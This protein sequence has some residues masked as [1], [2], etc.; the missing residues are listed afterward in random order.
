[1]RLIQAKVLQALRRAAAV[2]TFNQRLRKI[3]TRGH[4]FGGLIALGVLAGLYIIVS[5]ATPVN[6]AASISATQTAAAIVVLPSNT[7]S[8]SA[9]PTPSRTPTGTPKPTA[10]PDWLHG[11]VKTGVSI[12]TDPLVNTFA[13]YGLAEGCKSG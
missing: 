5:A 10:T 11:R 6:N 9:T 4:I 13:N 8:P 2:A 12:Y 1:M 7:P 3:F